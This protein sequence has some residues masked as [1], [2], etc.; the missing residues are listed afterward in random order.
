MSEKREVL[1][2][3]ASR[4]FAQ[5]GFHAVGIDRIIAESGVAKMTM[6]KHF[7]SKSQLVLDV[8]HEHG[9][10]Q[11]QS[12]AA[13]VAKQ[14]DP[15]DQLRAVFAWH[16][17]WLKAPDFAGCLFMNAAAEFHNEDNDV[18][19]VAAE[20]HKG[21]T[22]FIAGI[23]AQLTDKRTAARLA[24]QCMLLLDGAIVAA[25]ITGR[26]GAAME[27]WEVARGL[28]AAETKRKAA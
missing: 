9:A 10:R 20:Q 25:H 8:L 12:L 22:E 24:R 18:M 19:Q 13:F 6:Y 26:T 2:E 21:M 27:A 7:A 11:A 4:L 17:R 14:R 16:D 5:Y 1:L 23:V 28:V 3:T 15:L